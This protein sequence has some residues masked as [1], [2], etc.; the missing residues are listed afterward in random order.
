LEK[1]SLQEQIIRLLD[2]KAKDLGMSE[3]EKNKELSKLK[4]G[5]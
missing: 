2:E 3:D 4:M 1:R 5:L